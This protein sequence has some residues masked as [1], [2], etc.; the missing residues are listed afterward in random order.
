[1]NKTPAPDNVTS[2]SAQASRSSQL[3]LLMF[4]GFVLLLTACFF[5]PFRSLVVRALHNDLDSHTILVPIISAYLI[6]IR[7]SQ[8]PDTYSSSP[9]A[10]ILPLVGGIVLLLIPLVWPSHASL[11]TNDY[12]SFT[13]LSFICFLV[14]GGFIFLGKDWMKVAAFPVGFLVFMVP[15]PGGAVTWLENA[16]KLASAESASLLFRLTGIPVLR[17]GTI[18]QLPGIVIEVAQECSGI[19]SSWV[20]F[21]ASVLSAYL[22]LGRLSSRLVLAGAA[23]PLGI[24]RNGFRIVVISLLCVH[25][26]PQMIHSPIH[27]RGGPLF[28]V[29]SLIP[30]F[31]LLFL[32]RR[33]ERASQPKTN[34]PRERPG[35]QSKILTHHR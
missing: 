2:D 3:R 19:R 8:L 32:L 18:F 7:R 35:S 25:Y 26:G 9:K 10:A 22:F 20:L 11:I 4:A 5:S 6:Y 14:T 13:T 23:I 16:S 15:L 28:F 24:L 30:L 29:V 17:D 33:K 34:L 12:L 1:V 21:I 31:L 27:R